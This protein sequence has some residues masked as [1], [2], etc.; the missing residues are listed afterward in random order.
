MLINYSRELVGGE[1]LGKITISSGGYV[2]AKEQHFQIL[3]LD[4]SVEYKR[5]NHGQGD[6]SDYL[7][8]EKDLEELCKS[9]PNTKT[10]SFLVEHWQNDYIGGWR[11]V[12]SQT[13]TVE[14]LDN[15]RT[16]PVINMSISPTGLSN[17]YNMV[18][19]TALQATFTG[20]AKLG[21][22]VA[23]Y[24]LNV[25]GKN[26]GSPYKSDILTTGGWVEV[27]GTVTDTRGFTASQTAAIWV[28]DRMPSLDSVSGATEYLDGLINYS[29]KPANKDAYSRLLVQSKV[30]DSYS[31]VKTV[32]IGQASGK[33]DGSFKIEGE[34]LTGT[35]ERYPNTDAVHLR[36]TLQSYK[37]AYTDK[38]AEEYSQDLTLKIPQNDDTKPQ[39]SNISVSGSPMLFNT[40][41]FFVKSKNGVRVN[42]T[43]QG[44]YNASPVSVKW[45]IEDEEFDNGVASDYFATFGTLPITVTVVDSRGF[46]NSAV[47]NIVVSDY[48]RP[49]VSSVAGADRIIVRRADES[50]AEDDS[51]QYLRI[52]AGKRYTSL[53]GKNNCTLRYRKKVRGEKW[54]EQGKDYI[55]L[56]PSQGSN[57]Y[58]GTENV[59][60]DPQSI[61]VIELSVIDGFSEADT[62]VTALA[63]E[64]VYMDRS[65][66]RNSIAFGGHI[67][68][69]NSFEV[70]QTAFFRGGMY[71]DDLSTNTRYKI[72]IGEGG[73]LIAKEIT[74]FSLRR[75]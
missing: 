10:I 52:E 53:G 47:K 54:D 70:Y 33:K 17:G 50:G 6:V 38:L 32:D 26:Y 22:S 18:G 62:Y 19:V 23:S 65:G 20:S 21:A 29:F 34:E 24:T 67:T 44:R 8:L 43:A 46:T 12:D 68:R 27:I 60:L 4:R 69:D 55:I 37:G 75:K 11:K 45:R 9:F 7:Y 72:T 57:D 42:A 61:Y 36:L 48:Q 63:T 28:M 58:F 49:Y 30:G 40:S 39:I 5:F 31:T 74:T 71:F 3:S 25:G 35:Y 1:F 64:A 56:T 59:F 66:T 2:F 14:L 15:S 16:S 73:Q 41:D 51:G 13:C